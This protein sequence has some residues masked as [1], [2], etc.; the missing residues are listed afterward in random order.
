MEEGSGEGHV[1]TY[2]WE[3]PLCCKLPSRN[4]KFCSSTELPALQ[5]HNNG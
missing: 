5:K 2:N 1:V 3:I 4:V